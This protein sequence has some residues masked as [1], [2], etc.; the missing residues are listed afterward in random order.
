M[1]I[2][3][4]SHLL[5]LFRFQTDLTRNYAL[6]S[7]ATASH[8]NDFLLFKINSDDV[9]KVHA[10]ESS[11]TFLSLSFPPNSWHSMCATWNSENGLAQLWMDGKATIKRFIHTG[12]ITGA[13]ITILGQDQDSLGGSFDAK[14][15]FIGMITKVHMWDY[16][17]PA[18]EI[19]R[20]MNDTLHS[21][22]CVQLGQPGVWSDR[23]GVCGGR[24]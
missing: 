23:A 14:Q 8:S 17:L 12:S 20:Y 22:Q 3:V 1:I 13:P 2:T 16:V 10:R 19:K 6:F 7:L 18:A 21:R 4:F 9:I 11:T 5:H 15:C 24:V